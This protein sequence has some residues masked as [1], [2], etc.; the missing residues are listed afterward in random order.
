MVE[1][2]RLVVHQEHVKAFYSGAM[3]PGSQNSKFW[4]P[5]LNGAS[6]GSFCNFVEFLVVATCVVVDLVCS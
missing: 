5:A 4:L 2:E 1:L 6:A 3:A